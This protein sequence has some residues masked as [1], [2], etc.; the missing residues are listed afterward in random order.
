MIE[1]DIQLEC[2]GY[3]R[4]GTFYDNDSDTIIFALT[5][6]TASRASFGYMAEAIAQKTGYSAFMFDY[7]G[8]GCDTG[9]MDWKQ[10]SPAEQ[11]IEVIHAFDWI[12]QIHPDKK[13]YVFGT[14]FGGY[15]ATQLTKYRQFD[16]LVLAAPAIYTPDSFYDPASKTH[17]GVVTAEYRADYTE[18]MKHPLLKRA[19]DRFTNPVAVVVHGDD[20]HIPATVTDAYI[21]SFGAD[22]ITVSELPHST[23][24]PMLVDAMLDTY[25]NNIAEWLKK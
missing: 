12:R 13:I 2:L 1:K 10:I 23:E 11:F 17:G 8:H 15:L 14:S 22:S 19:A 21:E 5:G 25:Q 7:S 16:K 9:G 3:S 4:P 18:L 24:E 20:E 6:R